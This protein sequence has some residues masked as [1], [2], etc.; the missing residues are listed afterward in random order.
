MS[1]S[2]DFAGRAAPGALTP[3]QADQRRLA[4]RRHGLWAKSAGETGMRHYRSGRLLRRLEDVLAIQGRPLSE[5]QVPAARSWAELG[6]IADGVY[7]ALL[8]TF[9]KG[10]VPTPKLLDAWRGLQRDRLLHAVALGLTPA[11]KAELA[12]T[13]SDLHRA[14]ESRAAH[15]R[16]RAKQLG[17]SAR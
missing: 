14:Q 1:A 11:A 12:T 6:V 16:L 17:G 9:K 7:V 2:A 5:E 15:E 8:A 10:E 4:S 3:S 13:L